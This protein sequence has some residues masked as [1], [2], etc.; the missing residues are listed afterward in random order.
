[1]EGFMQIFVNS[2]TESNSLFRKMDLKFTFYTHKNGTNYWEAL[3][4]RLSVSLF[5]SVY[6]SYIVKD[7]GGKYGRNCQ[8]F[9]I[10]CAPKNGLFCIYFQEL[11]PCLNSKCDLVFCLSVL[12]CFTLFTIFIPN[13]LEIITRTRYCVRPKRRLPRTF[14]Q[15]WPF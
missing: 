2:F 4:V 7:I 9:M 6:F 5:C 14:S 3:S 12:H 8:Q 11:C 1:M 10:L 15:V 13:L